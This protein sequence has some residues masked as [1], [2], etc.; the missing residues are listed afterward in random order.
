MVCSLE[1]GN[2]PPPPPPRNGFVHCL[3]CSA[4]SPP[5]LV[6]WWKRLLHRI[7]LVHSVGKPAALAGASLVPVGASLVLVRYWLG[8]ARALRATVVVGCLWCSDQ[9]SPHHLCDTHSTR[10]CTGAIVSAAATGLPAARRAAAVA[11]GGLLA[12]LERGAPPGAVA[13]GLVRLGLWWAATGN[14]TEA[15]ARAFGEASRASFLTDGT[16]RGGIF[17]SLLNTNLDTA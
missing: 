11:E 3:H 2:P 1:R 7:G 6:G 4:T 15:A 16:D 5:Q 13:D 17:T 14:S 10:C 12:E 8:H 9:S